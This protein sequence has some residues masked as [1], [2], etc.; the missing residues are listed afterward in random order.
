MNPKFKTWY[1]DDYISQLYREVNRCFIC[2]NFLY[3]NANRVGGHNEC[4]RYEPSTEM[5]L[6]WKSEAKEQSLKINE[7][8]KLMNI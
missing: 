5:E 1:G 7:Y 3:I 6:I 4:N 8:I 2:P